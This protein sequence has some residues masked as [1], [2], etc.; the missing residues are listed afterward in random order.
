MAFVSRPISFIFECYEMDDTPLLPTRVERAR[1]IPIRTPRP[2]LPPHSFK[3]IIEGDWQ[4]NWDS[5]GA[6][7][8]HIGTNEE[9]V[10]ELSQDFHL[11]TIFKSIRIDSRK[12]CYLPKKERRATRGSSRLQWSESGTLLRS[13]TSRDRDPEHQPRGGESSISGT[14]SWTDCPRYPV[15]SAAESTAVNFDAET[16]DIPICTVFEQKQMEWRYQWRAFIHQRTRRRLQA[17]DNHLR[18]KYGVVVTP[19]HPPFVEA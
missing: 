3:A 7:R 4:G 8:T 9:E 18:D 6:V 13:P 15:N 2:T 17:R 12:V 10:N 14:L 16:R 11:A 1:P 19:D 5:T